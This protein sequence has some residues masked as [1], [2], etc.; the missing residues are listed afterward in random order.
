MQEYVLFPTHTPLSP[1]LVPHFHRKG[2][3][4]SGSRVESLRTGLEADIVSRQEEGC[5]PARET[6]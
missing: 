3:P 4:K 6:G 5:G 1:S 2:K